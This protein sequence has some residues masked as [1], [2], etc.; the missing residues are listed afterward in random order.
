MAENFS[1]IGLLEGLQR[2]HIQH[3]R[4]PVT[5]SW[6]GNCGT[7]GVGR[8]MVAIVKPTEIVAKSENGQSVYFQ[9]QET[10]EISDVSHTQPKPLIRKRAQ[11]MPLYDVQQGQ[12]GPRSTAATGEGRKGR[13]T[14]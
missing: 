14:T 8:H 9:G 12:K 2:E 4:S 5:D 1:A 11:Q 7:K 10:Q 13:R 6:I 3:R